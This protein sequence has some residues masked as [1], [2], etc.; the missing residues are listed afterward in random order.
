[1]LHHRRPASTAFRLQRDRRHHPAHPR[2]GRA[3]LRRRRALAAIRGAYQD[4]SAQHWTEVALAATRDQLAHAEQQV[5]ERNRLTLQLQHAI[6]PP[7]RGPVEAF[8]LH[9]AVRYRPAEKEH[10]VGGD[11]YDTFVLPSKQI[12]LSVGDVAGHGIEAA[13]GMVVLRNALR[14]LAAT[15]AGPAQLL[16]WLNLVAHHLTE[17]RHRHRGLRALRP[18]HPDPALGT[19]RSPAARPHPADRAT[20]LPAIDGLLLGAFSE[21]DYAEEQ[22]QLE[23]G[24]TLLMYTDGLIERRDHALQH[25]Q[26]ELL[27]I[28]EHPTA[29][30]DHRL[31]H[32]LTHCNSD[33]D[34]DTCLIGVQ[35][36]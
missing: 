15:G 3:R 29:N 5:D 26:A 28:A 11:W 7:T 9:I 25:S 18:R 22:I 31:D 8:G 35:L 2:R 34:D 10:L 21:A 4:I 33:T 32:L 6:M 13:T 19:R 36:Q 30:L 24:D 14:G 1:M 23:Q 16:T 12:L 17:Q 27:V 20:E